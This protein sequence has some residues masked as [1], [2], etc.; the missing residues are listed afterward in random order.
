VV[1]TT[2]GELAAQNLQ[3][4]E[5]RAFERTGF[6]YVPSGYGRSISLPDFYENSF[7]SRDYIRREW[8]HYFE[9]VDIQAPEAGGH[10][11]AILLRPRS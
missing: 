6:L 11:D 8:S 4:S 5:R 2:H 9:V 10:Q 1:L 3:E 7:H